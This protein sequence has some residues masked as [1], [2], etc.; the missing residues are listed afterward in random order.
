MRRLLPFVLFAATIAFAQRPA[1]PP[2]G[3]PAPGEPATSRPAPPAE[4]HPGAEPEPVVTHHQITI[5][6]KT[7]R[8]TATTG[9]LPSKNA[10]GEVEAYI[11]FVAYQLEGGNKQR[12]LT[13]AFNGGPGSSSV[14][15]HMGDIGPRRVKML[16][17]GGMPAP[18]FQLEDNPY[19]WLEVSDLVF[20]DPVGTGY[21]RAAKKELGK[22]FWGLNGDIASVGE[23][24]RYYLTRYERWGAPLFLAGESYGTTRASGLSGYLIDRGIPFNGIILISSVLNFETLSFGNGND[25]PYVLYLP[26][27]TA[28]AWFH[29]RLPADLQ[30]GDVKKAIA[31][32]EAWIPNYEHALVQGDRL[33]AQER[34]SVIE[35][36]ARFTGLDKALI[37]NNDLRISQPL[38]SREL[39]RGQKK[40]VGRLDSRFT[41]FDLGQAGGPFGYDPSEAAI[42]PPYTVLFNEYVR[43]ELGY[44]SDLEYYILGGGINEPW[45]FGPSGQGYANVTESL[46]R[47]F[48]KDP[49]LHLFVA[50]GFYDMAT[51]MYAA[52]Y[53]VAHLQLDAAA[54]ANIS[55][56]EYGAG[57]MMY[58]RDA[59]MEALRND[60]FTFMQNALKPPRPNEITR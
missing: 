46:R 4:A 51:P 2:A 40:I 48:A 53:T 7:L 42:R 9:R 15:L 16:P 14:W 39:L 32:V 8:Y 34:Q 41:G 50:K 47:A 24:I 36:L 30:N 45:D 18:P 49:Y 6:G 37:D 54:R 26:S 10:E 22:K 13:F 31:A 25:L 52:D 11:F 60:V 38:F 43:S 20:I 35:Q 28:A 1:N 29:K 56:A 27:Y 5:G 23:F 12:P 19:T 3:N 59:D 55:M 17:E 33:S 21:S 57:H 44:K 58:I